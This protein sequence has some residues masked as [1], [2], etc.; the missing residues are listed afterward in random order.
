MLTKRN[1]NKALVVSAHPSAGDIGAGGFMCRCADD[2]AEVYLL[3]MS[4]GEAGVAEIPPK[5][6]GLIREKEQR[7]AAE[8]LG[9]SE[10][11]FLDIKDTEIFDT[12][13][14]RMKIMEVIRRFKP[15]IV[16]T[17]SE[18][19]THPDHKATAFATFAAAMYS[20][21]PS[22]KLDPEL[23]S[24]LVKSV[25][26]YG[27]PGYSLAFVP[28]IYLDITDVIERKI[29]A[30]CCHE[31]TMKHIGWSKERWVN[32]WLSLDRVYG[33]SSGVQ[34]AEGFRQFWSSHIGRRAVCRLGT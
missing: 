23:P 33:I 10:V 31:T 27:L 21:L 29:K 2:G 5:E 19:D 11:V 14:T 34:Y 4:R 12:I 25:Y 6:L 1:L 32:T 16:L 28:E 30:I 7:K 9:V 18:L 24:H 20:S 3:V 13:S 15:E 17:H 26:T 8:I 22:V